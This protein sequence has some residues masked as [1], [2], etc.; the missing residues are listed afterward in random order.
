[1]GISSGLPLT[2]AAGLAENLLCAGAAERAARCREAL[3]QDAELADAL[4]AGEL[5]PPWAARMLAAGIRGGSGDRVLEE[6]ARRLMEEAR[7]S[8][9]ERAAKV[10]PAMVLVCSVLMGVILLSTMLP[11]MNIMASIG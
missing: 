3:E 6:I 10:E 11:L 2:E 4:R 9:E 1:M 8:L 5:L 7:T